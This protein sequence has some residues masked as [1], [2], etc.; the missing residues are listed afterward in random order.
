M[1]LKTLS[2]FSDI[3]AVYSAGVKLYYCC[4]DELAGASPP[5]VEYRRAAG[6]DGKAGGLRVPARR[7]EL[8][9]QLRAHLRWKARQARVGIPLA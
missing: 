9:C 7:A 8:L 6:D 1:L 2:G 3:A 4:A 5:G